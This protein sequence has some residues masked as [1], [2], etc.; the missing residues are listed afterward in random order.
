MLLILIAIPMFCV[1]IVTM[2]NIPWKLRLRFKPFNCELCLSF[3]VALI[4]LLI[5]HTNPFE[6]LILSGASAYLTGPLTKAIT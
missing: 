4:Y 1:M 6:A 2:A 3:W 5:L